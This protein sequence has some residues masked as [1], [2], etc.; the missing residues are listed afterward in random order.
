MEHIKAELERNRSNGF[1]L[2][3]L[4]IVIAI[5]GIISA[6]AF[7]AYQEYIETSNMTKVTASYENAVRTTQNVFAKAT[8][9]LAIGLPS[10]I[11]TRARDWIKLYDAEEMEA[12]GGGPAYVTRRQARRYRP[13]KY[14]GIEVRYKKKKGEV[15]ITRPKYLNLAKFRA[16]VTADSID[17]KKY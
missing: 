6:A 2:V 10:G 3:E 16:R 5:I 7:P 13:D 4:M 17:V 1:T 8:T 12:P 9:Q 11:P 14:G 15:T